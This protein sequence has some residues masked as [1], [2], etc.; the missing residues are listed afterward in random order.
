MNALYRAIGITKQAFHK[1]LN[2]YLHGMDEAQQLL[3]VIRQIRKEHPEMGARE[4]YF[5]IKPTWMGRDKFEAFCLE[6]GFR[7][8]QKRSF[9]KTTNSLGVTRFPNLL[10]GIELTRVNQV[11]VSDITYYAIGERFYYLTFIMDLFSRY[12]VGYSVAENL[13]T[14]NTTIPALKMALRYRRPEPG[15]IFHSDGGG[16]YYSNAF[17]NLTRS[18]GIKNSMGTTPYENPNAERINGTIK[19]SYLRHYDPRTYTD[20]VKQTARAVRNYNDRPHASLKRVSPTEFEKMYK[21]MLK[22]AQVRPLSEEPQ[23]EY[24]GL[25]HIPTF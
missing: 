24:N 15:L 12:V 2:R 7:V 19:N 1:R 16:Q 21:K 5:M 25:A 17:K 4:L 6:N 10:L 14:E 9:I 3:T 22:C 11:W 13:A 20:L 8:L 23:N 18:K